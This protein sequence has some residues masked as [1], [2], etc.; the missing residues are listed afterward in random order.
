MARAKPMI[1][2]LERGDSYR[3]LMRTSSGFG[4]RL[5][6]ASE[7]VACPFTRTQ[8]YTHRERDPHGR[9]FEFS[10]VLANC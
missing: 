5:F 4:A 3:S 2:I 1:S 6:T 7:I 9:V 10:P 8:Q